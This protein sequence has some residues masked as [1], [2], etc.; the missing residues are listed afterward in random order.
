[1]RPT[2]EDP[3]RLDR[4]PPRHQFL[5]APQ[6]GGNRHRAGQWAEAK[7]V[8]ELLIR[9]YPDQRGPDNAHA[10][11]ATVHRALNEPELERAALERWA[12]LDADALEAYQ[13]LMDALRGRKI[14]KES[15]SMP[16][17]TWP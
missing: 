12:E 9:E 17:V 11:L 15:C 4:R 7:Q 6:K 3:H 2:L 14:G 8:L 13:R 5:G 1:M 16:I 10:L